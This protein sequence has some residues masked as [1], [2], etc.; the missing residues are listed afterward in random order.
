MRV[1]IAF[2]LFKPSEAD[3]A[4][5]NTND[6]VD[7]GIGFGQDNTRRCRRL[8]VMV[9]VKP[10]QPDYPRVNVHDL[11]DGDDAIMRPVRVISF[12]RDALSPANITYLSGVT[13]VAEANIVNDNLTV[14]CDQP[15]LEQYLITIPHQ[16]LFEDVPQEVI[17]VRHLNVRDWVIDLYLLRLNLIEL[18]WAA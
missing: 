14:P 3:I 7:T 17:D 2:R 18:G 12:G 1:L 5:N 16:I 6:Y 15:N 9:Y 8:L 4:Q 13:G 11:V 10:L